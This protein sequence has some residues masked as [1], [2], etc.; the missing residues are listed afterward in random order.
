MTHLDDNKIISPAQAAYQKGDSTSQQLLYLV[1]KIREA[2]SK[3]KVAHAVFIN[4][5]AAFD[6][7]WHKGLIKNL[8]PLKWKMLFLKYLSHTY[9]TEEQ[10]Q[11][12]K[13]NDMS[14]SQ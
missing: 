14:M 1:N 11:Q 5:S 2:W 13:V 6:A 8:S 7:V 3:D 4:V 12:L 10:E 9:M